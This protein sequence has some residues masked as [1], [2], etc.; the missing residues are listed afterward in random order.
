MKSKSNIEYISYLLGGKNHPELLCVRYNTLNNIIKLIR[1][2]L[3]ISCHTSKNKY[4]RNYLH[5]IFIPVNNIYYN[6]LYID[7]DLKRK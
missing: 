3:R 7:W 5:D 4:N 6:L 2:N 1:N